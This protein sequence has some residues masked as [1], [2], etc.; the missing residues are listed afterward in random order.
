M[1]T[2]DSQTQIVNTS[3][4]R[5]DLYL[6]IALFL[7]DEKVARNEKFKEISEIIIESE[8]NHLLISIAIASR[9][10][11]DL[12]ARTVSNE[13]CGE[14]WERLDEIPGKTRSQDLVFRKACNIIIHAVEILPYDDPGLGYYT[15]KIIVRGK[16][17]GATHKLNRA[18]L[19]FQK[20]SECCIE[21]I[22][23]IAKGG[24]DGY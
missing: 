2:N 23:E 7:S 12:R 19:D 18:I 21:L 20:Y 10:L 11:L 17:Q 4:Y 5:R 3:Y 24:S 9:Q 6:L 1:P 16:R 13:V 15:G 14:I 8:V 22:D